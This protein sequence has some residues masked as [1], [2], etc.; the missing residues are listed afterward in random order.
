MHPVNGR[1]RKAM[2]R[3]RIKFIIASIITSGLPCRKEERVIL[4]T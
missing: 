3:Q 4:E 1:K 2:M